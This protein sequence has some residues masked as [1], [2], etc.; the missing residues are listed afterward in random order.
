MKNFRP[1]FAFRSCPEPAVANEGGSVNAGRKLE[2]APVHSNWVFPLS[3]RDLEK[4][5]R[6]DGW[7]IAPGR[8]KGSH[9][10]YEKRGVAP[11]HLPDVKDLSPVVLRNTA[12]ALGLRNV[13]DLKAWVAAS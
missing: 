6:R 2:R 11:V 5:L 3:R 9:H 12:H 10:R 8:G 4:S 13:N 1:I 7:T